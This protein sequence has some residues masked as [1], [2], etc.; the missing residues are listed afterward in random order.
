MNFYLRSLFD[1]FDSVLHRSAANG[2]EKGEEK[3]KSKE[4]KRKAL[5]LSPEGFNIRGGVIKKQD[6]ARR[7]PAP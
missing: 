4:V 1:Y 5:Q 7:N 6:K 3:S 2:P